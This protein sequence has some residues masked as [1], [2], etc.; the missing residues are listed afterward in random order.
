MKTVVM[1]STY[2]ANQWAAIIL[3]AI[4]SIDLSGFFTQKIGEYGYGFTDDEEEEIGGDSIT[5]YGST[6]IADASDF[7]RA[8]PNTD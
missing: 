7:L 6:I 2:D 8:F 3:G 1:N 5:V 4:K